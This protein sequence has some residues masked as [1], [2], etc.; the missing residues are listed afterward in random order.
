MNYTN[1]YTINGSLFQEFLSL[2]GKMT[3]GQ[4][5]RQIEYIKVENEILRSKLPRRITTTPAEKRRL[6]KYGVPLGGQIKQVI[7][8]VGYSTFRRWIADG[9]TGKNA[10]KRGRPRKTTQEII[11]LIIRMAK[12]NHLWGYGKIMGELKKLGLLRFTRNTLKNILIQNGIDPS[13]KR[14]EDSWDAFIKRHFETLWACDFFTKTIW[15]ALGPRLFHVLFFI[16]IRTRKVHIAGITEKP[17]KDWIVNTTKSVSFLFQDPSKKL[18][19]RDGDTKFPKEFDELFK[20][21][22]A[23]VKR[24]PYRSPNLNPYAEGFVGTIKRECLEHFFV[25]G[26]EHFKYLIREYVDHYNT[27]RPH[28]GMGNEPL[29]YKPRNNTGRIKCESRL[30]GMIKHYYWD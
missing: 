17:N 13:P 26:E 5:I 18:L 16:N 15:T 1:S 30:G 28:S 21:F 2:L 14:K 8:I 4:L 12:E 19:I 3:Q 24:I 10:P 11:D 25:F 7:S 22:N 9:V 6:I 23:K 20:T 29:D 27:K